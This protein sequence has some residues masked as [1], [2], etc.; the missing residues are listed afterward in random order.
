MS[1]KVLRK[2]N[3]RFCAYLENDGLPRERRRHNRF[4]LTTRTLIVWTSEVFEFFYSLVG[5]LVDL[6]RAQ[7]PA[8]KTG[9]IVLIICAI[10]ECP[11]SCESFRVS[12]WRKALPLLIVVV[13]WTPY[14]AVIDALHTIFRRISLRL[15]LTA[16]DQSHWEYYYHIFQ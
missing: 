5:Y 2:E 3:K 9:M 12:S 13:L 10:I 7:V 14:K 4:L 8:L 1:A 16:Y 11:N 6:I 15:Y